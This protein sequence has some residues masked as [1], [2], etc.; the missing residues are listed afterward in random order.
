[1]GL[2]QF[3]QSVFAFKGF[4]C[5]KIVK[6]MFNSCWKDI[7]ISEMNCTTTSQGRR[8]LPA[9]DFLRRPPQKLVQGS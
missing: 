6:N 5:G 8:Q 9:A 2:K 7:A 4:V 1:M 3:K